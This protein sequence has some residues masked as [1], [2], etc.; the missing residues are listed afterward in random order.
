[1]VAEPQLVGGGTSPAGSSDHALYPPQLKAP[2]PAD[3]FGSR[4]SGLMY[5][6]P[7]GALMANH[8]T[9]NLEPPLNAAADPRPVKRAREDEG[10]LAASAPPHLR[11]TPHDSTKFLFSLLGSMGSVRAEPEPEPQ[12]GVNTCSHGTMEVRN[13]NIS[14]PIA[15]I[16]FRLTVCR[17]WRPQVGPMASDSMRRLVLPNRGPTAQAAPTTSQKNTKPS[18]AELNRAAGPLASDVVDVN[19]PRDLGAIARAAAVRMLDAVRRR[20]PS[21]RQRAAATPAHS[22]PPP[23]ARPARAAIT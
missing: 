2:V 14:A 9:A 4:T 16:G 6:A 1:M 18:V 17:E 5:V 13:E 20:A 3:H 19:T 7:L 23:L 11:D 8:T 22:A 21:R 15:P 12:R 10:E